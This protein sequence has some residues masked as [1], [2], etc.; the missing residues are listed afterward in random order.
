M[1]YDYKQTDLSK[2]ILAAVFTGYIATIINLAYDFIF[3][4][5]T[6]FPLSQIINVSTIIFATL[7]ILAI[8][9]IL[10]YFLKRYLKGGNILFTILFTGLTALSVYGAMHVN[11]SADTIISKE[12][13]ELLSGIVLIT[14]LSASFFFPYA[15]KNSGRFL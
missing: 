2:A 12:F 10:F 13:N 3:R 7:L 5:E 8:A 4:T 11:R 1:K 6:G 15:V 14:G 9:G